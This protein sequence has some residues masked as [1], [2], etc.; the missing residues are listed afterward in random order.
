MAWGR[1]GIGVE[2]LTSQASLVLNDTEG[3]SWE[4][5]GRGERAPIWRTA[6]QR[7]GGNGERGTVPADPPHPQASSLPPTF[8]HLRKCE[9]LGQTTIRGG[10]GSAHEWVQRSHSSV[11]SAQFQFG[12]DRGER[13]RAIKWAPRDPSGRR[14]LSTLNAGL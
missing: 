12:L 13:D 1:I 9:I 11:P 6:Q 4:E 5:R 3:E 7:A 2:S 14:M 8:S 10:G